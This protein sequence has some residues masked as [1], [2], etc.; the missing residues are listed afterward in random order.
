LAKSKEVYGSFIEISNPGGRVDEL[1]SSAAWV[2]ANWLSQDL[3][4]SPSKPVPI[5]LANDPFYSVLAAVRALRAAGYAPWLA[6]SEPGTFAAR[7]W[8]KAGTVPVPDPELDSEGFVREL[9]AAAARLRVAAV[10]PT[11][12]HHL[13]VLAGREAD[14]A[15]I[16]LGVP[17][18]ETVARATDKALLSELAQMAGLNTPPTKKIVHGDRNTAVSI[19]FPAIIKPLRSWIHD[20]DGTVS[21]YYARYVT[22]GE[23]EEA[24]DDLPDGEGLVQPYIDGTLY[25][26]SGV[27]W[28]GELICAL[29]MVSIRRW[30][31]LVGGSSY[32][33]TTPRN[34]E[35]EQGVGSLLRALGWSGLFQ[36]QFMHG[37]D[38]EYYLLD[39][40]P[41]IYGSLALAPAAGLNLPAI[42]VDLLLGK[43]PKVG[44]YRID[45]RFRHEER[46][47][48]AL[49]WALLGNEEHPRRIPQGLLPHR[50]TAHAAMSIRDPAPLL[51]S[52]LRGSNYV[53]SSIRDGLPPVLA[54]VAKAAKRHQR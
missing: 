22:E 14:F 49:V 1:C 15:G 50:G 12:E 26:V 24:L 16:P 47:L 40:N 2:Q 32:A 5:L 44:D 13:P 28:K 6:V 10:L 43:R 39:L 34:T 42:W 52:L 8:A 53:A 36:A 54:R 27:G 35:L 23:V 21:R 48:R 38:G 41:R 31:V 20:P 25:S 4:M 29:H 18:R 9:A 51:T 17:S 37:P 46:D 3:V 11:A 7:S 19:G 45:A 30:P 33:K